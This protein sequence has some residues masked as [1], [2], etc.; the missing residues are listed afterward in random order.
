MLPDLEVFTGDHALTASAIGEKLG[1]GR[2]RKALTGQD[3][4]KISDEDLVQ[5]SLDVDIYA[6]TSRASG[7]WTR[8][9]IFPCPSPRPRSF[10]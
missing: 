3:L 7:L 10:G 8:Q 2:G 6:R 1:M 4:E 9:D 5:V